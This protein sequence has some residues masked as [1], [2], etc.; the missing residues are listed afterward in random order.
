MMHL[1]QPFNNESSV[2]SIHGTAVD[3]HISY[4]GSLQAA[5]TS[6]VPAGTDDIM[7]VV[8][9]ES[10]TCPQCWASRW[11]VHNLRLYDTPSEDKSM[12]LGIVNSSQPVM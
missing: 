9:T 12:T 5:V 7:H 10:G 8:V 1:L 4:N 6:E 11:G 2:H 3:N